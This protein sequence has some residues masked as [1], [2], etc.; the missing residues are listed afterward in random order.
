MNSF[1]KV[2]LLTLALVASLAAL[3]QEPY[4]VGDPG[5]VPPRLISKVDPDYT[6][7]ARA[8]KIQGTVVIAVVVGRSGHV[9]DISITQSLDPGLDANA[10]TAVRQWGF[11]P[12]T[13]DGEPVAVR[14]T[15]EVT[16]RLQ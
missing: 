3:Q 8:A 2:A 5:V 1:F 16:F 11:E 4:K 10:I 9:E 12:G 6:T 15:I 14:A 7:E 13:R